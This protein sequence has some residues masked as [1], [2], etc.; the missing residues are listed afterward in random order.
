MADASTA[1]EPNKQTV[2]V[3]VNH[4]LE[5]FQQCLLRASYVHPRELSLVEDQVARFSTWMRGIGVFA[6]GR[7]SM[8]HRLRYAPEVQSVAIG[9]LESLNYRIQSCSKAL[10]VLA[11]DLAANISSAPNETIGRS[12]GEIAVEISHLNKMSNMI[13]RASKE[14]Q[15][16][17]AGDFRIK[18]D[19]GNDVEPLLLLHFARHIGDRF[20]NIS[21]TLQQRLANAMLLRRKRILQRRYRQGNAAIQ[22]EETATKV[23]ISFPDSRQ[24]GTSTQGNLLQ[25]V[26]Y[27]TGKTKAMIAPSLIKSATTLQP[28]KFKA[29]ASS[30]SVVSATETVALGNHETLNFPPAP[31]LASKRK[32]EQ[33]KSKRLAAHQAEIHKLDELC[34]TLDSTDEKAALSMSQKIA[35]DRISAEEKLKDILKWIGHLHEHGQRWR[36]SSHRELDPFSTRDEYMRH[37]REVHDT[38]LSDAKLRV[39]AN[40][41]TRKPPK[42]F[43]SCP[44]CGVDEAEVDTRLEDHI[45]GHL[46]SLAPKSLPSYQDDIPDDA[47]NE[48]DNSGNPQSRSRSTVNNL[49]NDDDVLHVGAGYFEDDGKPQ[50]AENE[51]T[52]FLGNV[53]FNLDES[54]KDA[55]TSWMA[56]WNSDRLL[57]LRIDD[58]PILQSMQQTRMIDSMRIQMDKQKRY[59]SNAPGD[60]AI[61]R[62]DTISSSDE[63]SPP[64]HEHQSSTRSRD[65]HG[66]SSADEEEAL[67]CGRERQERQER[68]AEKQREEE[69][70]RQRRIRLRIAKAN[71]EI[72]KRPSQ[73]I[74]DG[75]DEPD[76][77]DSLGGVSL[78]DLQVEDHHRKQGIRILIRPLIK[79]PNFRLSGDDNCQWLALRADVTSPD[80]PKQKVLVV[81]QTHK[82]IKFSIKIPGSTANDSS[83][84]PLWCE[85]YYDPASHY[86]ILLNRSDVPV[87]ISRVFN[88][89]VAGSLPSDGHMINPNLA[90]SLEP[91]TFRIRVGD[92]QM[93]EFRILEKHSITHEQPSHSDEFDAS[94]PVAKIAIGHSVSGIDEPNTREGD[95]QAQPSPNTKGE[96]AYMTDS[97]PTYT[98]RGEL[99]PP[100][101]QE[102]EAISDGLG[103]R[104]LKPNRVEVE[105]QLDE[106]RRLSELA[107]TYGDQGRWDEAEKL[108]VQV[109]ESRKAIL[110]G[111]HP[112]TLDIMSYLALNFYEQ[113]RWKEAEKL[114]T[115][116]MEDYQKILGKDHPSSLDAMANL[117][118]T[119]G[120]QGRWKEAEEIQTLMVEEERKVFGEY[121]YRTLR[122]M[123]TLAVTLK[124]LG[125]D[126]D[127]I[128]WME[129]CHRGR[130]QHL[131]PE[132]PDTLS[133]KEILDKWRHN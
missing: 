84:P 37:M 111:D 40:R 58:D 52:N 131:G 10:D 80:Q 51:S 106:S 83:R 47:G 45:A 2:A 68:R 94:Q 79:L 41:N 22:L 126:A 12:F 82:D 88:G 11:R 36:C 67:R 59:L 96:R 19:E 97:S 44:L 64:M 15:I 116:A 92:I 21:D 104:I 4:C 108:Q 86:V 16:L 32:Y 120:H 91:G 112:E 7:A 66:R 63:E 38:K 49:F 39:L 28:N 31:G 54:H 122:S 99:P 101:G 75:M 29:A 69:E 17:K 100:S 5:S 125:R 118:V 34:A 113:G 119:F 81:T 14:T 73:Q 42:L 76:I 130:Q 65:G 6:P 62:N 60:E 105:S 9:L 103:S 57:S 53:H 48:T 90:K 50:V 56:D 85:M 107:T 13:R 33:L 3:S 70:E 114:Q 132:H 93:L 121:H 102:P 26:D 24:P 1:S 98:G 129:N 20:P 8:D 95:D 43:L 89:I 77:S 115:Q 74:N 133:V 87:A 61:D 35:E 127:A 23:S 55:W 110:G 124:Q 46:R 71:A 30:P 123:S 18:D 128:V 78:N 117:A 109:M 25:K 72:D 27:D